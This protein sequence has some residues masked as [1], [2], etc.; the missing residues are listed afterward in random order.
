Y[1]I[2]NFGRYNEVYGSIGALMVVMIWI[3]LNSFIL[4]LGFELNASLAIKKTEIYLKK[5]GKHTT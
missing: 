4:L 1:F 2:N 3:Q 5:K